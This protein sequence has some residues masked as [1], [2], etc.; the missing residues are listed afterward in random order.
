M[1]VTNS[2][3]YRRNPRRTHRPEAG[4]TQTPR[5]AATPRHAS[6]RQHAD[7]R[8]R[9]GPTPPST[10]T[11]TEPAHP[12]PRKLVP[13]TG[14]RPLRSPHHEPRNARPPDRQPPPRSAEPAA[15]NARKSP[16]QHSHPCP[17]RRAVTRARGR[18]SASTP[19]NR[20]ADRS[21]ETRPIGPKT[22]ADPPR[23]TPQQTHTQARDPQ[24]NSRG[25]CH[26]AV[27]RSGAAPPRAP[28]GAGGWQCRFQ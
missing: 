16:R 10:D 8:G 9:P 25:R 18:P 3:I 1:S 12:T 21:Q 7:P 13:A 5:T 6:T 24:R 15:A 19:Q 11:G 26:G 2:P 4:R 14:R 27:R 17:E 23:H 22:Q 20:T 28:R